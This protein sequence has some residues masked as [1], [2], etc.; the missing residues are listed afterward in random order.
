MSKKVSGSVL[1]L[2][3]LAFSLIIG[4]VLV[5]GAQDPQTQPAA[6][7][8][9]PTPKPKT[10]TGK[11]KR[12]QM[13]MTAPTNETSTGDQTAPADASAAGQTTTPAQN[14]PAMTSTQTDLSGTYAGT[15]NCDALG[16]TGDTT[17]TIN[18]NQFSTADGKTGRIV[19]STTRGYTA[20]ALQTGDMAG[21]TT[22]GATTGAA[23]TAPQIVSLRARKSG[24]RLT[25]SSV[26]GAKMPCSFSSSRNVAR[27]MRQTPSAAGTTVASPAE[28][29]ATPTD[30]TT[31]AKPARNRRGNRRTTTP[32]TNPTETP[33]QPAQPTP[34]T[35]TPSQTPS[36]EPTQTPSPEP[37]PSPNPSPSGSPT[38][39]PNPSPSP[40]ATPSPTP[41]PSPRPR[42]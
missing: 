40:T 6:P 1:L 32:T 8:T 3:T 19:A 30:V 42:G 4:G 10:T 37:A 9:Q 25:L 23:T 27:R 7:Q 35:P 15:F 36:P 41:S 34:E 16:L 17:L 12:G 31:P 24:N 21:A 18:G 2:T 22:A 13:K 33:A 26:P 5:L 39:M 38:P 28:A 20:V 14:M 29:G 11:R